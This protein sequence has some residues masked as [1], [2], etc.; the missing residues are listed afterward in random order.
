MKKLRLLNG[1]P[2]DMIFEFREIFI[3]FN[4]NF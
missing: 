3:Y 1:S 4:F 2:P